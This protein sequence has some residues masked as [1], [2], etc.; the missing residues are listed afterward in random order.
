MGFKFKRFDLTV[1]SEDFPTGSGDEQLLIR[2]KSIVRG[3]AQKLIE[4]NI[5]WQLDF[6]RNESV[7]D[8]AEVPDDSTGK[9]PGLFLVNTTSGCKLFVCYIGGQNCYLNNFS[10]SDILQNYYDKDIAGLCMSMIPSGSSDSFGLEFDASF[11]P[12]DATR[13]YGTAS[14]GGYTIAYGVSDAGGYICSCGVYATE[15]VV[16]VVFG[17]S[18][19]GNATPLREPSYAV[20]RILNTLSHEEDNGNCAKYGVFCI[21]N[22]SSDST[23][24]GTISGLDRGYPNY[25]TINVFSHDIDYIGDNSQSFYA[26]GSVCQANGTWL[27]GYSDNPE[28]CVKVYLSSAFELNYRIFNSNGTGKSRWIPFAMAIYSEDLTT[29]GVVPGDGV[30][31]YLDTDLFRCANSTYGQQFDNGNF[32]AISESYNLLMG[33]DPTNTD[34]I[35]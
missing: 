10:G 11:L 2:C 28:S 9:W 7:T 6:S 17:A 33:W 29:C 22:T 13:I 15:Y 27:S 35:A 25:G 4:M 31:G 24:V 19:D 12:G 20:G 5:G 32:I 3:F 1:G 8:Y 21:R 30:K 18:D 34:S 14:N 26:C 23:I 16:S